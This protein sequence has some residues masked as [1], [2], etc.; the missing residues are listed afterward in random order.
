MGVTPVPLTGDEERIWESEWVELT[1]AFGRDQPGELIRRV[2]ERNKAFV[3]GAAGIAKA[4]FRGSSFLGIDAQGQ[5]GWSLLRPEHV[6]RS[7]TNTVAG[8]TATD[9][10]SWRRTITATGFNFFIGTSTVFNQ[11]SRRALLVLLG[12]VNHDPTPKSMAAQLLVAGISYP[13]YELYWANKMGGVTAGGMRLFAFPKP[14]IIPPLEQIKLQLKDIATGTDEPQLLGI[15]YAE[16][17]YLQNLTPT[18]ESP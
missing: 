16:G 4:E 9:S 12:I 13:I 1:A 14:K 17:G 6:L 8:T 2:F 10:I 15:T 11:I 3:K 18:L 5:F 7:S